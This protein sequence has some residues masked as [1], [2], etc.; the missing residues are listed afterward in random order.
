[1]EKIIWHN[2][3]MQY[4][5]FFLLLL[6]WGCGSPSSPEVIID[7]SGI[8]NDHEVQRLIEYNQAL[9]TDHDI[10]FRLILEK[11][12]RVG[13]EFNL[14]ANSLMEQLATHTR[15]RQGRIILLYV[16]TSSNL[17]RLEISGDLEG[18]YTDA[19]SGYIQQQHMVYFFRENRTQD[20][21]LA[22]SEMIYERARNAGLGRDFVSPVSVVAGGGGATAELGKAGVE[23]PMRSGTNSTAGQFQAGNS[24]METLGIY[25]ASMAVGNSDP[26]KDIYTQETQTMMAN[27]TV[28]PAQLKNGVK[29]IEYCSQFTA[30]VFY[31]D[32]ATMAVI[33][34]PT[35]ERR[36]HPWFMVKGAG[37]WRLDLKTMQ[38]VIA[39]NQKNQYRFKSLEHSYR[40][41]FAD[42]HFDKNG[43]PR[44]K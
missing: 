27:W 42:L 40:F 32:N 11:T 34:Y 22:A 15:S 25:K 7:R 44:V 3:I 14:H 41:A 5:L 30:R 6:N 20:G 4:A 37:K 16:D 9:L 43:F 13:S 19:F 10:D 29:G 8:L 33:R 36:C 12:G 31:D 23:Q 38:Q 35:E 24:P 17:A 26:Q 1:M 21:V 2:R 28:T 39:F 18:V